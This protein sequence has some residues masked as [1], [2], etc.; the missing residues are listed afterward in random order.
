M[1]EKETD[2]PE[3]NR[4]GCEVWRSTHI[5]SKLRPGLR[6]LPREEF[7]KTFVDHAPDLTPEQV[8][9]IRAI[10]WGAR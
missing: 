5:D 2:A 8:E 6:G 3:Y 9:Y 10:L 4:R 1:S 7:I